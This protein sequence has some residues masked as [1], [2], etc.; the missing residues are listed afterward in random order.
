[1]YDDIDRGELIILLQD[2]GNLRILGGLEHRK[3]GERRGTL[4][5]FPNCLLNLIVL[6]FTWP[7]GVGKARALSLVIP[8]S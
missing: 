3:S 5:D 7:V 1:M 8:L 2:Y 4:E 6:Q